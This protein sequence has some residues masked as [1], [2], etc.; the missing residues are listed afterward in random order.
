[1]F[2]CT[3]LGS[4]PSK[5]SGF[6]VASKTMAASSSAATAYPN[7]LSFLDTGACNWFL[8]SHIVMACI[9]IHA[10]FLFMMA[11]ESLH[12]DLPQKI[13][14]ISSSFRSIAVERKT[15]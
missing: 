5:N 2:V 9:L 6:F 7:L 4:S 14:M 11:E 15:P 8:F 12:F 1:M 10:Q 3:L 13:W